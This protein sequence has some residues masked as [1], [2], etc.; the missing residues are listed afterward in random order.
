M[1]S[2]TFTSQK[3]Q[4]QCVLSGIKM[5]NADPTQSSSSS[6]SL[7]PLLTSPKSVIEVTG[8]LSSGQVK[9]SFR[10]ENPSSARVAFKMK[11]SSSKIIALRPNC[12]FLANREDLNIEVLLGHVKQPIP[13]GQMKL[14]ILIQGK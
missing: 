5:V 1:T 10:L 14:K 12:G 9:S 3:H 2:V 4:Q 7:P 6:W 11:V 13:E 8:D